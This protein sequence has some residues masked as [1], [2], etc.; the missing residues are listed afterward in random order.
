MLGIRNGTVR[1]HE[2]KPL[3]LIAPQTNGSAPKSRSDLRLVSQNRKV[4]ALRETLSQ[5][6]D[7][8]VVLLALGS[9]CG[10][11]QAQNPPATA[12]SAEAIPGCNAELAAQVEAALR[13][14][15]AVNDTHIDAI[16]ENGELVLTGQVE[17][18]RALVDAM[19]VARRA[20]NGHPIIDALSIMKT[21]PR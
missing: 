1:D 21:S 13:A 10:C 4:K 8:V 14:A 2:I 20:A 5:L 7:A 12:T 17:D 11:I 18:E 6:I 16:C 3:A 15:P 9:A 19:R